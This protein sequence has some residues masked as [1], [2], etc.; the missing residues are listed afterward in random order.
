MHD[1]K[2]RSKSEKGW[3]VWTEEKGG[4]GGVADLDEWGKIYLIYYEV[5]AV[6]IQNCVRG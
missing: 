1:Q 3:E 2:I 6:R 5:H 4:G